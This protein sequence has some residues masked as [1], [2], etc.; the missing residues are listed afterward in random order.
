MALHAK[1]CSWVKNPAMYCCDCDGHE[2]PAPE[3]AEGPWKVQA[4]SK[5]FSA[6]IPETSHAWGVQMTERAAQKEKHGRT[7]LNDLG[8]TTHEWRM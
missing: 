7:H 5:L 3:P 8:S 6:W 1:D 4:T 2:K